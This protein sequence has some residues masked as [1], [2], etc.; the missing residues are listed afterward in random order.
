MSPPRVLV[1]DDDL[2][3]LEALDE[4]LGPAGY[5]I[6]QAGNGAEALEPARVGLFD[7]AVV[8]I[9]MPG[10]TG[11]EVLRDLKRLDP[12]A[13]VTKAT[14][15]PDVCT[16]VAARREGAYEVRPATDAEDALEVSRPSGRGSPSWTSNPTGWTVPSC[17]PAMAG[18]LVLALTVYAMAEK[19]P[20]SRKTVRVAPPTIPQAL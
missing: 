5:E 7:G 10:M 18:L 17:G 14:V 8:D 19:S 1:V 6:V 20:I 16:A 12:T 3:A 4:T 15:Q 9:G 13:E 11:L 2:L